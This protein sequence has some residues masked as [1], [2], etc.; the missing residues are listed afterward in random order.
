[1]RDRPL[2]RFSRR[3]CRGTVWLSACL[4]S[5]TGLA[6]EPPT[7]PSALSLRGF[8]TLGLAR[9]TN[10]QAEVARDILQAEGVSTH[11][12]GKI[13]SII[14]VQA[15]YA[16]SDTVEA[17]V[18]AISRYKDRRNFSP[19]VTGAF[20][21]YTPNAYLSLR[22]GRV[23]TDFFMH[24]DSR[25]IGY[26]Q[27]AVRPSIDYFSTLPFTYLDGVDAQVT[28]PVGDGLWLGKV[29]LGA[30][31][32]QIPY[33][34]GDFDLRGARTL[35]S[36][37]DYQT[38]HWQWRVGFG[39]TRFNHPM[40]PPIGE[41][42]TALNSTGV[43]SAQKAAAALDLVGTYGRYYSFGAT[44][45]SGPLIAQLMLGQFRYQSAAI[46]DQDSG[47]FLIGYRIGEMTP[48][49]GYSKAKSR[50]K[51]VTTGL[52]NT[53][54]NAPLNASLATVLADSATNQHTYTFGLRWDVQ[55]NAALKFQADVIRGSPDSIYPVRNESVRWN[56]KTNVFSIALDFVF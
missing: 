3:L 7:T 26:S 33:P 34:S 36:Y 48:F 29:Y 30:F 44:Y 25:L 39:Q 27:L 20:L 5:L 40:A 53:A 2:K 31:R 55:R 10:S 8:G 18:Q 14:G 9:S 21:K 19:D 46:H 23:G 52:S 42:R 4:I 22:G 51:S 41:L 32:E 54:S 13:D 15:N 17:V 49:A 50:G 28:L 12:S 16:A 47:T 6:Q 1:M 38:G 56:G 11:W 43:A 45:D 37:I 35:G 24:A